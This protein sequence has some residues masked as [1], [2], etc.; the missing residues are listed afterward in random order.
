MVRVDRAYGARKYRQQLRS[1]KIV[2]V[3]PE[4]QFRE[5]VARLR[6]A[7]EGALTTFSSSDHRSL[8]T[9]EC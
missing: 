6:E 3:C 1:R 2:C 7:G 5:N 9:V 8:D 4:R